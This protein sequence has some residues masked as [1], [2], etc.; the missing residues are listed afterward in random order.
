MFEYHLWAVLMADGVEADSAL[1]A[2]LLARIADL[3]DMSRGSFHVTTLNETHV[4]ATG[5]RNHHQPEI[6]DI[7][8]WIAAQSPSCYG[9][10]YVRGEHPDADGETRFRVLRM[11]RGTVEELEDRYFGGL[12]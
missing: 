1:H 11:S 2:A 9:L 8:H 4:A 7:F 5:L 12:A 6:E 10:L 3:S